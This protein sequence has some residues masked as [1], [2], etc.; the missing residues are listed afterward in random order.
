MSCL[1]TCPLK[2]GSLLPSINI[3]VYTW[4]D[5][6]YALYIYSTCAKM[7]SSGECGCPSSSLLIGG[8]SEGVP[9]Q[10]LNVVL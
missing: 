7:I 9:L 1:W 10:G 5:D 3:H 8:L 2:R 4:Y 6:V